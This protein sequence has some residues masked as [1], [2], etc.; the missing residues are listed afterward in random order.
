[1]R[2]FRR[3]ATQE[4]TA[5]DPRVVAVL[6]PGRGGTSCAA[7]RCLGG[8]AEMVSAPET[9]AADGAAA[10]LE[11]TRPG[12][13]VA[14][15]PG[16]EVIVRAVQLPSADDDRLETALR[17]N[18]TTFVLGRTPAWRV[19]SAVLPRER[20]DGIRTGIV[21]EWPEDSP[22][23]HLPAATDA[24]AASFAPAVAALAAMASV[25]EGP[26]AWIDAGDG[27]VSLAVPT[28]RGLL[29]RSVRA[30]AD[31]GSIEPSDV[32]LAVGEACVHAGVPGAEIPAIV[33][34][35]A[36]AAG[37]ALAGGFGCLPDDL[38]RIAALAPGTPADADWWRSHGLSVG[39]ALAAGG[40]VAPLAGLSASD[41]G[42]PRDRAAVL[43]AKVGE[44]RTARRLL[45]AGLVAV[46]LG[47]MAIEGA[48]LL[49]LRW[50]LPDMDAYLRAEDEDRRRQAMYRGLS[51]QGASMTKTLSDIASCAPDG[52]EIEFINVT[53]AAGGQAVS[54]RGKS[55]AAGSTSATEVLL[56]L[57]RQLRESGAFQGIQRSSDAPDSRGYQEFSLTAT[58]VRPTYFVAYPQA[59]DY[60][61]TSMRERR[62]GPPPE[63]VDPVASGIDAPVRK[64][65]AAQADDGAEE[66]PGAGDD[67]TRATAAAPQPPAE[68]APAPTPERQASSRPS[69]AASAP[70]KPAPAAEEAASRETA[71]AKAADPSSQA[72]APDSADGDGRA[73]RRSGRASRGAGGGR[74]G[75]A[76]R[77][78]PGASAEPDP[79]PPPL[80]ENEIGRMSPE[81]VRSTLA[82]V[83]KI[84][85][86]RA[87]LDDETKERLKREFNMLLDRLRNAK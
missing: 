68:D 81:E 25:A 65:A 1:M 62:Y 7:F 85:N 64:P 46:L 18:A 59:Q 75:L 27:V 54:I 17:L 58:A 39:I 50:K 8:R 40:P 44:P 79:L 52:V 6:V 86:E 16:A 9:H 2:T 82:A 33:E 56:E 11:A 42:A 14:A 63:D 87:D 4:E 72:K 43:L 47:P 13:V 73:D 57:E 80:T 78:N 71:E 83:A 23:P 20:G 66:A 22:V 26:L 31:G 28:S 5:R 84:R 29:V 38:P 67:G 30:G 21:A 51:R 41:P 24:G 77:S 36:A 12:R 60:A 53:P 15:L 76:T 48:R 34:S 69:P 19:A 61:K 32:S 49:L 55:R 70:P 3:K 45:A 10:W 35:T 74:S 37:S